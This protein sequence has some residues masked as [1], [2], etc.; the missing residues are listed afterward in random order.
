MYDL[1]LIRFGEIA[2]KGQ[3]R[4]FFMNKLINN[5]KKSCKNIGNFKI[6]KQQGRI[7]LTPEKASLEYFSR[8]KNVPGIV[9]FSPTVTTKLDFEQLKKPALKLVK[10]EMADK[11]QPLSFRVKTN[12]ANKDFPQTSL[13]VSRE[14]GAYILNNTEELTVDLEQPDIKLEL[15]IRDNNIYLFTKTISGPGG[16]P[17]GTSGK[18]LLLLSGGIDSPVAGWMALKRG[19]QLEAVHFHTPP[20]TGE[21]AR[22]KVLDICQELTKTGLEIKLHLVK[23]TEIQRAIKKNCAD[24]FLITIMRRLMLKIASRL[25]E[26][27]DC[28]ALITGESIGQV[29]SQTIENLT[30]TNR[31]ATLPVLRPLI[32]LNKQEIVKL[33]R[34]IG[35][36]EISIRP[37]EDCC[38]LFVPNHPA[39]RPHLKNITKSEK[40]LNLDELMDNI[41]ENIE[42]KL[43]TLNN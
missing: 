10:K 5:I 40:K 33:A 3:N 37:H 22:Q 30:A 2:L 20:Y 15:D 27:N 13:E 38:T 26:K 19:L 17:V 18:G 24:K 14:L 16:L 29:S 31:A 1:I 41:T 8:L 7:F 23:F 9:S 28:Q 12:R 21:R 43:F 34:K 39:T 25:A 42:T 11:K 32:G 35:T 6:S 4:Q 36:Y